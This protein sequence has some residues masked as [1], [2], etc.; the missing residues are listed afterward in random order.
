MGETRENG[1]VVFIGAGLIDHGHHG[2][3]AREAL[4]ETLQLDRAVT[5]ALEMVD[6][7]ETLIITTADHSH[8]LTLNGYPSRGTDIFGI[9]GDG[10]DHLP[11]TSLM[12]GTGPGYKEPQS[13][14][15]RYDISHDDMTPAEYRF[16]AA[17]PETSADHAGEDVAIHAIGPQAHLFRGVYQQNYIP[18]L[19]AYA[20][21]IGDGLTF[22][23]K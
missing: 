22:C 17:V 16:I 4:D 14:G 7:E 2:N 20:A 5:A 8:S 23:D 6:I 15:S 13:D 19:L 12:Y 3:K 11:Y 21:C 1:Y 10:H 9:G 18:H